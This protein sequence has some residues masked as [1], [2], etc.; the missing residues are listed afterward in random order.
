MNRIQLLY[1]SLVGKKILAALTGLILFGFLIGHV[2]GN[3]KVFTGV[4]ANG[5]PHIDIYG[6]FLRTAG[7]PMVPA[8]FVLWAVRAVLLVSL[9]VHVVV[10]LQLAA[11]NQQARP[12]GYAKT[13]FQASTFAARYM[14]VTGW[15]LLAFII[16]HILHFTTG[17]IV[18]GGFEEGRVYSNLSSS[19][20]NFPIAL[21]YALMMLVLSFHLYHGVWSLFQTLG[22]DNPDRNRMLRTF[23]VAITVLIAIGFASVP[24]A[25]MAGA[26]GEPVEYAKELLT[27]GSH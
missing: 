5:V 10:V 19:F 12:Q 14:L 20:A 24:L 25:F 11:I 1:R 27:G 4:A 17:T 15:I 18:I 13:R 22:W 9:V 16:F 8:H 26:M 7:E 6:H 21:V 23:A 3:L 2:A